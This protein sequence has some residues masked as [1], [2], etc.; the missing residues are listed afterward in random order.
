MPKPSKNP[1]YTQASKKLE[2]RRK[3]L[4]ELAKGEKSLTELQEKTSLSKPVILDRL[5]KKDGTGKGLIHDGLVRWQDRIKGRS[6]PVYQ[7]TERGSQE[8]TDL[9]ETMGKI[10]ETASTASA[11]H[12]PITA[13]RELRNLAEQ[14]P[15]L[16]VDLLQFVN[17]VWTFSETEDTKQWVQKHDLRKLGSMVQTQTEIQ[18]KTKGQK[19]LLETDDEVV[20][21]LNQTLANIK[22]AV[23][24]KK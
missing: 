2:N 20:K 6:L 14:K 8:I 21:A 16:F 5:G 11:T 9:G 17:E 19:R 12:G 10:F 18:L 3:I 7:I 4:N 23:A 24:Q 13:I 1:Y 22:E 15:K